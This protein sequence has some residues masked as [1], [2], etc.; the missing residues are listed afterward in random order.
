MDTKPS[1]IIVDCQRV[2]FDIPVIDPKAIGRGPF[3]PLPYMAVVLT[4]PIRKGAAFIFRLYYEGEKY[5]VFAHES[6]WRVFRLFY[7]KQGI[8]TNG[9]GSFFEKFR[10]SFLN[11]F[12][13]LSRRESLELL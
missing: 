12:L 1:V 10:W 2:F 7:L 11:T 8:E 3:S 9:L 5:R 6:P 4:Y 13:T